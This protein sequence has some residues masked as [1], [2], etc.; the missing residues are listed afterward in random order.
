[1]IL[2][3]MIWPGLFSRELKEEISCKGS[4]VPGGIVLCGKAA[5]GNR[6]KLRTSDFV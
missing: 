4:T 6:S 3:L 1:M 5:A 2:A